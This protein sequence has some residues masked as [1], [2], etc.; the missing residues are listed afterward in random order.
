MNDNVNT[1]DGLRVGDPVI[2]MRNV[3]FDHGDE[4]DLVLTGG[5]EGVLVG[6]DL[7]T[8][9]AFEVVVQDVIT[10]KVFRERFRRSELF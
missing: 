5:S 10:R 6:I 2:L 9:F 7:S 3:R 4:H 8:S 1:Y